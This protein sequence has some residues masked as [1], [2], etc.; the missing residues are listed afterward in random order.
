M[1][2]LAPMTDRRAHAQRLAMLLLVVG[3]VGACNSL[4]G[5]NRNR[6]GNKLY[7]DGKFVDAV[8][9]FEQA[10]SEVD[11]PTIHYNCGLAYWKIFR[12]QYDKPIRLAKTSD[13]VCSQIPNTKSIEASV[14]IREKDRHYDREC[15]DKNP[16]PA[17][18]TCE[19]TT[20][21]T[22][23]TK[24]IAD[25]AAK[26]FDAWIKD[27]PSDEDL[28][29]AQKGVE[30]E[31]AEVDGKLEKLNEKTS[32][33]NK[34]AIARLYDYRKDLEKKLDLLHTKEQT[35]GIMTGMWIDSDQFKKALAYWTKL[36]DEKPNNPDIMSVL[37][38]I[39]LKANDW[40]TSIEWYKKVADVS[41]DATAKV[42][43]FQFI[44]N[45]A[46][47]KL[48]SKS[49]VAEKAIKLADLGIGAL[50]KA[51]ELAPENP[52]LIGL[53]GSLFSFRGMIQGASWAASIDRASTQ[54]LQ[55]ASRVLMEQAK[56]SQG[57]AP[58]KG[59]AVDRSQPSSTGGKS[60]G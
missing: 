29:K 14:C 9:E 35:R 6:H 47:T 27:Q 39:N 3:V 36:L 49:L 4:D 40:E 13:E 8:G 60:G 30:A 46:W 38:G 44:G 1:Y 10:L 7:A 26:H 17:L 31:M 12:A 28:K 43:A 55:R 52:R 18:Y 42:A 51:S 24:T 32:E 37:A 16:C 33:D 15:D 45:V 11:N 34:S 50:Q 25:A 20:F 2:S 19:K 41:P 59:A 58:P 56:K 48:N 57:Q 23:D 53:M 21:C 22:L 5:R 54:D